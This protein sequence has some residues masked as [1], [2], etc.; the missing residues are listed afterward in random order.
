MWT[1]TSYRKLTQVWM[2]NDTQRQNASQRKDQNRM[3]TIER[4]ESS[5]EN[6]YTWML[7]A[8]LWVM[9]A[10][11]EPKLSHAGERGVR[12][13]LQ[14]ELRNCGTTWTTHPGTVSASGPD[15]SLTSI[16]CSTDWTEW[17]SVFPARS[18]DLKHWLI[19]KISMSMNYLYA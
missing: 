6:E 1:L 9:E 11:T 5:S 18:G 19:K 16:L 2:K 7:E 13:E 8:H 14:G 3:P 10:N 4:G 15:S 12:V 17:W